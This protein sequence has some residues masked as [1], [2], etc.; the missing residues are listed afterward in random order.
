MVRLIICIYIY[1]INFIFAIG[2]YEILNIPQ[3]ASTL[4]LNN[5]IKADNGA[6]LTNNP[7]TINIPYQVNSYYYS[8]IPGNIHLFSFQKIIKKKRQIFP[9]KFTFLNYGKI[10]DSKSLQ[11]SYAYDLLLEAGYKKEFFKITSIGI[12]AGYL[13]SNIV[14]YSSQVIFSKIGT[15]NH[16]LKKKLGIGFSIENCGFILK[17]YTNYSE[18]LPII[19]RMSIFYKPKYIP[20]TIHSNFIKKIENKT[21]YFIGG[22]ELKSSQNFI[23]RLG[24]NSDRSK[25]Y[26]NDLS[27]DLISGLSAG[28]TF[29]F[30][31]KTIDLGFMNMGPAGTIIGFSIINKIKFIH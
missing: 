22:I 10:I 11:E 15:R 3:D 23:I 7:A 19:Y 24:L 26:T 30:N 29:V 13:I 6:L 20:L 12:S 9:S 4:G 5:I 28:V 14:G 16:L 31:N 1:L 18:S 17:K 8:F 25:Y 2:S 27:F 21:Y